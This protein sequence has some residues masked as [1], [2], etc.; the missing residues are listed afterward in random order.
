MAKLIKCGY[1]GMLLNRRM[2]VRQCDGNKVNI[3]DLHNLDLA[4]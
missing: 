4:L 2:I 3:L 1:L